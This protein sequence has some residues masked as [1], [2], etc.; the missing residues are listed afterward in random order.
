MS[1]DDSNKL[2]CSLSLTNP[3]RRVPIE[4]DS[5]ASAKSLFEV[6]S[7]ATSIPV[8]GMKLIFRGRIIAY[9]ES[10]VDGVSVIE[11]FKL[12]NGSVIHC[13]GKAV[14][15]LAPSSS[16]AS[17][18][19]SSTGASSG[20][21][22]IPP[23][24]SNTA[25]AAAAAPTAAPST[26]STALLKI[27]TSHPAADYL[28]ALTTMSKLL[29]NV[30]GHPM[31]EKY[32][33]VKR[34]N[35]AFQ[36][37]LGRLNGANDA[38]TAIGF[39]TVG[40]E[41]V[42]TPSPEAWPKLL[43]SKATLDQGIAGHN[44]Q[45]AQ[46]HQQ[47]APSLDMGFGGVPSMPGTGTGMNTG[48]PS[49]PNMPA[50]MDASA[51]AGILSN[52]QAL[53]SMLSNPMVQQMMQNHPQLA[54]NPQMQE[55]MRMLAGNPQMVEQL[56]TLMR[57]PN[58]MARVSSMMQQGGMP[59]MGGM[60]G[61]GAAPPMDM[62]RQMEMMRQLASMNGGG[63]ANSNSNAGASTNV[64]SNNAPQQQQN[65]SGNNNNGDDQLTEEEMIAEAIARS[66]RER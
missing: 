10:D 35:A 18:S 39:T 27:K 51:M 55:Q 65:P 19:S 15:N 50:G 57:D 4:I 59:G 32:R 53:Q 48:M 56:S 29:S 24:A 23:S 13:M 33:K 7:Q 31:E 17:A 14:E 1:N 16:T 21:T 61:A 58:A 62:N 3:P 5:N 12:E 28:T 64:N 42:L 22:V 36:K 26:L 49:M 52:P 8:K 2:Q 54:N 41:Y 9:K 6:A 43:E 38:L 46:Q 20:S 34:T 40:E 37:R 66:L 47:A 44:A 11:E 25:A 45:Q 60:G 30:I 63:G